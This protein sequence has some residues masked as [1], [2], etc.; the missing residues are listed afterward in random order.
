MSIGWTLRLEEIANATPCEVLS[1]PNEACY[2]VSIDTRKPM[3]GHLFVA[4]HGENFNAHDFLPEAVQQGANILLVDELP[5]SIES[6]KDKVSIVK[7]EDTTKALQN[8]ANYW[9]KKVLVR[10]A[11]ITGSNGKSTTKEFASAILK[12]KFKVCATQGNLNNHWGVPL[13]L[14]SFNLLTML[15]LLNWA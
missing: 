5:E 11:A 14:L 10:V 8:I 13:T 1:Q 7:V 12:T 15:P 4:L 6:L 3:E 9:R 2:G